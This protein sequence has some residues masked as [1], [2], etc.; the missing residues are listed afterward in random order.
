M[1]TAVDVVR[2]QVATQSQDYPGARWALAQR[3][4]DALSTDIDA[5]LANGSIVRVH[6]MR[7]TWHFVAAADLRWLQA[8]T[9]DRVHAVNRTVGRREEIDGPLMAHADQVLVAALAGGQFRT[10][11]ELAAA[12]AAGGVPA[13]GLR[14]AYILM[15]AEL[16]ALICNGPLRG[17][18]HTYALVDEWIA[19]A[20]DL[21]RDEALA[22]LTR[23]YFTSHG[24]ATV[25][26]CAI[27]SGML[28]SDLRVG[29]AQSAPHLVQETFGGKTFWSANVVTE[30]AER[31]RNQEPRIHLLPNYDE[32]FVAFTDDV[33]LLDPAVFPDRKSVNEPLGGHIL[34][35]DGLVAGGWR[36]TLTRTEVVV[37]VSPARRLD[38]GQT[39][40]LHR[41]AARYG[42]HL[43]LAAAVDLHSA[44]SA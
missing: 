29:L 19:P 31:P 12:L 7:P 11:T 16:E 4:G 1:P 30:P 20:A 28:I 36:R 26:D 38:N 44:H 2:W 18:M 15:H 33:G 22:E 17:K 35:V 37:Q 8:L 43:G 32:Y 3:C 10:R 25:K 34:V 42:K 24:P 6:A 27:W 23:R 39:A 14:L 21:S 13:A 41:A 40:S 5:A 9:K